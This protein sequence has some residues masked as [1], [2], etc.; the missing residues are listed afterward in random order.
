MLGIIGAMD[1]E[2]AEIKNIM[3][4]A[5]K[6]I[7]SG[8][9]FVCGE[10]S[11]RKV[12]V[13]KCGPGKVNAALCA[14]TMILE[15]SPDG[16]VNTGVAGG[17]DERLGIADIA[18]ADSV[19]QHDCDTTV[20]GEPLGYISKLEKVKIECDTKIVGTLQNIASSLNDTNFLVG[21]VATG[22]QFVYEKKKKESIAQ[23]FDAIACEMEGGAIGHVCFANNVR[24][25]VLRVISDNAD[26][27][28]NMDYSQFIRIAAQKSTNIMK[29]FIRIY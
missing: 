1:I 12:V 8:L 6:Q 19:V 15:Y 3:E 28:S 13:A 23:T 27:S 22:D 18:I 24:F 4:N 29:Q 26:G 17:L 2:V 5:E 9:E 14:Q 10:F 7:I 20:F 21:T 25:G 16:I 11:G